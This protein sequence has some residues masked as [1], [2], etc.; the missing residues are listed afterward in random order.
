MT[1]NVA[2]ANHSADYGILDS[3]ATNL[4]TGNHHLFETFH[5]MAKGEHQ[6]KT[7]NNR[8]VDTE[9]SGTNTFDVDRP[10]TNPV[11]TQEDDGEEEKMMNCLSIQREGKLWTYI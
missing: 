3:G 5:P 2:S 7:A 4:V 11:L 8:F 9:D 6:V 1:V 10:N